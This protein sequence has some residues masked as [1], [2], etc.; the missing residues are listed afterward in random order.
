MRLRILLAFLSPYFESPFIV[1]AL[2]ITSIFPIIANLGAL[3]KM[4]SYNIW[5]AMQDERINVQ[6]E[7]GYEISFVE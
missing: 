5:T 1:N 3:K 7:F 4:T 6:N 2:N